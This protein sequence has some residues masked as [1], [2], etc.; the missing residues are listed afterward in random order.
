M[1]LTSVCVCP[2]PSAALFKTGGDKA[3]LWLLSQSRT[4][5]AIKD[6]RNFGVKSHLFV[7]LMQLGD[8][9][10]VVSVAASCGCHDYVKW[11]LLFYV[12][13]GQGAFLQLQKLRLWLCQGVAV[14][15]VTQISGL[16]PDLVGFYFTSP[17]VE[18]L[19]RYWG[20]CRSLHCALFRRCWCCLCGVRVET[21]MD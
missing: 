6:L 13:P 3:E 14:L 19:G 20:M 17:P 21:A 18:Y 5:H 4:T 11:W 16:I 12:L 7:V 8:T 15:Q 10:I 1:P 9:I 2:P